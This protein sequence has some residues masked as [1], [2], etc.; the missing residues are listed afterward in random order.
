[1]ATY[2]VTNDDCT[3][4]LGGTSYAITTTANNT[5]GLH[6]NLA[7]LG[8]NGFTVVAEFDTDAVYSYTINAQSV[9]MN[10]AQVMV[11]GSGAFLND[12][13]NGVGTYTILQGGNST[14]CHFQ[15]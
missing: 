8:N 13:A 1:M 15:F 2:I 3:G 14:I 12:G 10:G 6:F 9:T 5:S 7:N 11:S 4:G